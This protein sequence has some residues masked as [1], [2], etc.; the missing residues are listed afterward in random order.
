MDN[1][2]HLLPPITHCTSPTPNSHTQTNMKFILFA[3]II[4]FAVAAAIG[5]ADNVD[6]DLDVNNNNIN[7]DNIYRNNINYPPYRRTLSKDDCNDIVNAFASVLQNKRYK[8][9]AP[10]DT[11]KKYLARNFVER[12]GSIN[13]L[14][15][16][17][18][19]V[20][21]ILP[22]HFKPLPSS[23]KR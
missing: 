14:I 3:S 23:N 1:R 9:R 22:H 18:N 6:A 2:S 17:D 15:S 10:K 7:N 21:P 19:N 4:S 20:N 13:T 11:Y 5:S 8:N 12:S 16:P